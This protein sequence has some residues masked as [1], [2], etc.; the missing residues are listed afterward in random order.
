M[1]MDPQNEALAQRCESVADA[2][3]AAVDWTGL[4]AAEVR[5]D[6]PVLARDLRRAALRARK[7]AGAARRPMCV[8]VFGPSQQGK[9]YLIASLARKPPAPTTI[10]FAGE[11]RLFNRDINPDGG[12]ESTGLVTRF[13]VRPVEGLPGMP[14][15]CRMLSETDIVKIMANAFM[16]DFDRD[17]VQPLDA[18]QVEAVLARLRPRAARQPVGRLS[19]DDVYDLFEYFERYFLNHPA[20]LALKPAPWREIE[21]L[22]PRLATPDRAELYGLLWNATPT[23]T[24]TALKLIQALESLGFPE[25]ACCPMAAVEP[26]AASIIDVETM[27]SL[28]KGDGDT[29]AVATRAGRRAELPRAVLTA[30]VA[31]LQLQL[32]ERPFDFFDHTDL[33]DF[34]G[35]RGREKYNAAKAEE[36]ARTDLFMLLRRGKVA[37]LYQRYLAEQE[38]T[39]MLLCL[40]HSNQEVR[41]VP[42]MVRD[43]IDGTHGATPQARQGRD[44]ALFLVLT[45]FDME[46]EVKGG[47]E[48]SVE[49]WSTRLKTTIF[50]FLGLG[51]DWPAEWTPGR[52]FAN[53][54]WLRNPEVK[55]KGLLDY[56]EGGREV[57]FREPGRVA[58]L[59]ANFLANPDVQRHFADP[60]RAWE[61]GMA[62][63]DGGIGL[64]AERL[65]P[66]CN[67]QTKREQVRAA[68]A[69]QAGAIAASLRPYYV[70]SDVEAELQKRLAEARGVAMGL[71]EAA[72]RQAF[73]LLL[74]ELQVRG[75]AVADVFRAALLTVGDD[76]VAVRG[77]VGTVSDAD[78][79]DQGLADIFGDAPAAPAAQ[80]PAGADAPAPAPAQMRDVADVLAEAALAHWLEGLHRFAARADLPPLF[81]ME[82]EAAASLTGQLATAARRLGLRQRIARAIRDNAS[83]HERAGDQLAKRVLVAEREINE[84]VYALGARDLPPER[85]PTVAGR[86]VFT[87]TKPVP[88]QWPELAERPAAFEREIYLDWVASYRR[89]VEDNARAAAGLVGDQA[90]NERLGQLLGALGR[91]AA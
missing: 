61:A 71:T 56:D 33:L 77:P 31:E 91:A 29:V 67:P 18:A 12:K 65:R 87:R 3:L 43:W 66:V 72:K 86:P 9:S 85:R 70:S 80:K 37:Y 22:A 36:V 52:A 44:V 4:A 75:E 27:S 58:E 81:G 13:T 62:L 84:F 8:S 2:A 83:F 41:T 88:E 55:N 30:V 63:N 17:T 54:F 38:L 79:L 11:T 64:I 53:T 15:V 69:A 21:A 90:L 73:G 40:K 7:L 51:H 32:E 35:A 48:D 28:G 89:L 82:R 46:F 45:M 59:R 68:L 16:E 20:H 14:V 19:E 23:M 47:A 5:E 76:P 34:P 49:R 42:A 10:R 6:G 74:S 24:A 60:E 25:E 26:K 57:G 50:E 1:P 39:S 78:E